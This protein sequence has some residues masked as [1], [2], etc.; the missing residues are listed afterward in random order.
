ME[1]HIVI[2]GRKDLAH[3]V[4]EQLRDSI[5]SGR[6][7]A[8]VQ[9]PPSRLLAAQLGLSRKTISDTYSR[10]TYENYLVG[11]V[12]SGTFVNALS[13]YSPPRPAPSELASAHIVAKWERISLPLRHPTRAG[14]LRYDFLGGATAKTQFPH[15]EWRRCVHHA[16]RQMSTER[17]FYGQPEGLPALRAAIAGHI[18]FARGVRCVAEDVVVCNG[19][20]QALDLIARVLIEPGS[21]VAVED[22]GYTPARQLFTAQGAEVTGVPVDS[23]GI[24]VE[25]IP[26]DVCAIYVTPSHQM[27]LGMPMSLARRH[28]LL[29]KARRIGAIIIEDD[30]DSEFRY[31]GRPTDSLQSIDEHGVVAYVGTFSKTLLPELRLGYA[32][33][34][35]AILEAV[36]KAKQLTDWHTS[37]LPQ[38]AL[39]KFISEGLLNKHIRRCHSTYAGRRE[40]IL[41][42]IAGDLS[43][44][45]ETIPCTAGFHMAVMLKASLDPAINLHLLVDRARD[46]TLGLYPLDGFY[47][48]ASPRDGLMMGFGAIDLLDIDP[49]LDRLRDLLMEFG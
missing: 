7:A 48:D 3:Q 23:E 18:A 43:L 47:S 44:W 37:T 12:G 1:L 8:G 39:S 13:A 10:L 28:A 17:G 40:R 33:L 11:K 41:S 25:Q 9:L 24:I 49:A 42:R 22:P 31:E 36:I 6:L 46:K 32:V 45:L 14:T 38:W 4:Y 35:A 5:V 21:R 34:P 15:D 29:E 27:P 19:A 26:G 20:Q 30:Y 16:V 2:E